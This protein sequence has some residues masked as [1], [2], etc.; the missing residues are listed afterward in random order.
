MSIPPRPD[1]DPDLVIG[2][3]LRLARAALNG[4]VARG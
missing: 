4:E 1:D 3:A 2:N